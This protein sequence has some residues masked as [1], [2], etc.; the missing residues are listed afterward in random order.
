MVLCFRVL[1]GSACFMLCAHAGGDEADRAVNPLYLLLAGSGSGAASGVAR[2]CTARR[3]NSGCWGAPCSCRSGLYKLD[4]GPKCCGSAA[5]YGCLGINPAAVPFGKYRR[6]GGAGAG[7]QTS[8]RCRGGIAGKT[9]F[10]TG[11]VFF[12]TRFI[13]VFLQ[14]GYSN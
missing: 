9:G 8:R 2:F 13:N 7:N 12:A 14:Q 1:C 11:T 4:G 3:C 10:V 6:Q 5:S